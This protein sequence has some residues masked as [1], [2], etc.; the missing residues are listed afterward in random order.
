MINGKGWALLL[1]ADGTKTSF[2]YDSTLW[3][4]SST[5]NE[6]GYVTGTSDATTEYKSPLFSVYPYSEMRLGMRIGGALNW[7]EV[8]HGQYASM[9][10]VMQGGTV[11]FTN[12]MRND[13][14]ALANNGALQPYCNHVGYNFVPTSTAFSG[15]MRLRIGIVGNEETNC[16]H[17]NTFVGFG[18]KCKHKPFFDVLDPNTY[19]TDTHSPEVYSAVGNSAVGSPAYRS[20]GS[21]SPYPFNTPAFGYILIR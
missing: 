12:T 16:D 9:L 6:A 2:T 15:T 4:T 19:L 1:R 14:L 13:W 10:E 17:P 20:D 21:E 7:L 18:T 8:K 3:N 5:I 11:S